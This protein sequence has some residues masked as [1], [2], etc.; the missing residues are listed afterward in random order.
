MSISTL[1]KGDYDDDDDDDDNNNNNNRQNNHNITVSCNHME[2]VSTEG[3]SSRHFTWH[4]PVYTAKTTE[5]RTTT[6]Y[7]SLAIY[8]H[9]CIFISDGWLQHNFSQLMHVELSHA[10]MN[11]D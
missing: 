6:H 7:N 2:I 10:L 3:A 4:I 8:R 9:G 1:H 11:L 5:L